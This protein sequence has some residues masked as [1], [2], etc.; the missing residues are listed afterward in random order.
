MMA[1]IFGGRNL[2][3]SSM[4]GSWAA[5]LNT[6]ASD[7][8]WKH[9]VAPTFDD[10]Y[11]GKMY[12]NADVSKTLD[13]DVHDIRQ[14]SNLLWKANLNF[15]S[16][17]FGYRVSCVP[18]LEWIFDNADSF[19]V[20]NLPYFYNATMGMHFEKMSTLTKGT[21]NT[22]VFIEKYGYDTKQACHAMRCLYVLERFQKCKNMRYALFFEQGWY[23]DNLL[24]IKAGKMSLD[25]FREGV[26]MWHNENKDFL[27]GWYSSC[28]PDEEAK[29]MLDEG[30]K[31]FIRSNL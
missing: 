25:F 3:L 1:E 12:S 23:R 6:S 27:K 30:I 5:N 2:V 10:L 14:L 17:L 4:V 28:L 29:N 7:E 15:V 13:Y 26:E 19:A 20:M 16:V 21:S 18:E 31:D 9:F 11:T 22:Q 24:D 8:D